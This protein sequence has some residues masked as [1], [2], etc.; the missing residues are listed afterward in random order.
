LANFLAQR[1]ACGALRLALVRCFLVAVPQVGEAFG[2]IASLGLVDTEA[3]TDPVVVVCLAAASVKHRLRG[4]RAEFALCDEFVDGWLGSRGE[5][6]DHQRRQQ[7][8]HGTHEFSCDSILGTVR[9]RAR[10]ESFG[11]GPTV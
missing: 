8:I 3:D 4:G 11:S 6:S 9:R 10:S 7:E 1:D 2:T 5:G